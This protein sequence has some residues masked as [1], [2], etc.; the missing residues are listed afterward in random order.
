MRRSV[1]TIRGDAVP[2][3]LEAAA[4]ACLAALVYYH[5]SGATL[6][7]SPC[8]EGGG[9]GGGEVKTAVK[10]AVN[11]GIF[12]Q[13]DPFEGKN[14]AVAVVVRWLALAA[15]SVSLLALS[16]V[17]QA[18]ALGR[19][20]VVQG[21]CLVPTLLVALLRYRHDSLGEGRN[22]GSGEEFAYW[23]ATCAAL[24][25]GGGASLARLGALRVVRWLVRWW[26]PSSFSRDNCKKS[27]VRSGVQSGYLQGVVPDAVFLAVVG[28]GGLFCTRAL[29]I[30]SVNHYAFLVGVY[31]VLS[32]GLLGG[33]GSALASSF[34]VGEA[35][36]LA[37][38]VTLVVGDAALLWASAALRAETLSRAAAA[39]GAGYTAMAWPNAGLRSELSLVIEFGLAGTL[40]ILI[41][42]GPVVFAAHERFQSAEVTAA[43]AAEANNNDKGIHRGSRCDSA[44]GAAGTTAAYAIN[45]RML[46][47]HAACFY[48]T[49]FLGIALVSL[50]CSAVLG[51]EPLTWVFAYIQSDLRHVGLLGYWAV[52]LMCGI[53]GI[54]AP[55]KHSVLP[56]IVHRKL[57]HVL[58]LALF[59][60]GL[61]FGID[62]MRLSFAVALAL[63][64]LVEALRLGRV[65]PFGVA[66]HEYMRLQ[67]D[68]RD[69]GG[70]LFL[71]HLYLLAGCAITLWFSSVLLVSSSSVSASAPS[72]A[73]A[74]AAVACFPAAAPGAISAAGSAAVTAAVPLLAGASG[75]IATGVGDAMGAAV[76]TAIRNRHGIPGTR[77]SFEG[78]AA[79][80]AS[81]VLCAGLLSGDVRG[82]CTDGGVLFACF[83]CTLVEACTTTIDNMVLP[84][85]FMTAIVLGNISL[86]FT[87][88]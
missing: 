49:L 51:A 65:P 45:C 22:N 33:G 77:K 83:L 71:T 52:L 38:M 86:D 59:L 26:R 30:S 56:Q 62:F 5:S 9:G 57:F 73:A 61:F 44:G 4:A 18:P 6:P 12:A 31:T 3:A 20:G 50:A 87:P 39:G 13:N 25:L 24:L 76:G 70:P 36:L 82:A 8:G 80:F 10:T 43:A 21:H 47:H 19:Q 85:V 34:T 17:L 58:A 35:S 54:G 23:A 41:F 42:L 66:V 60:P 84:L 11:G 63:L 14:A 40:C 37:Q 75:L 79:M 16:L 7:E 46:P 68:S 55:G 32:R 67:V 53:V 88:F 78:S 29:R 48:A 74:V 72:A 1:P 27:T 81:M 28:G 64:L 15:L 2:L 69:E